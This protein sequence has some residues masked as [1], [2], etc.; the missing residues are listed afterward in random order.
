MY[1]Q[2]D[3]NNHTGAVIDGSL[4]LWVN[5]VA[6]WW[7]TM[8]SF[9]AW[10]WCEQFSIQPTSPEVTWPL[11][12]VTERNEYTHSYNI[13]CSS[14]HRAVSG[15]STLGPPGSGTHC[16]CFYPCFQANCEHSE[17]F[18]PLQEA[19]NVKVIV[20]SQT[21]CH[22]SVLFTHTTLK[23]ADWPNIT[24]S[25]RHA[26]CTHDPC[27]NHN[28]YINPIVALPSNQSHFKTI[29]GRKTVFTNVLTQL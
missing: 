21:L 28:G 3:E 17:Q 14:P 10:W 7:K 23:Q 18:S 13:K 22:C 12:N 16:L 26:S 1:S 20:L 11:Q 15:A 5:W 25:N 29:N 27:V 24:I 6:I 9:F 2:H 19:L 8:R 4:E